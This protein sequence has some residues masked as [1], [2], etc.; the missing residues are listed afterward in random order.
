M[1]GSLVSRGKG[2]WVAAFFG[3]GVAIWPARILNETLFGSRFAATV[4]RLV[5]FLGFAGSQS[6]RRYV[7]LDLVLASALVFLLQLQHS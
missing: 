2:G 6:L 4:R 7:L 1:V 5:R 3:G